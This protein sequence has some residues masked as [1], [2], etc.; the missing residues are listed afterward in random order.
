[1]LLVASLLLLVLPLVL[2]VQLV[3]VRRSLIRLLAHSVLLETL[4]FIQDK[5]LVL[6]AQVV[7]FLDMFNR[8][9]GNPSVPLVQL[10]LTP[11]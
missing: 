2:C 9:T 1:M 6:H 11:L 8:I 3:R 4:L 7:T 5:L 10:V